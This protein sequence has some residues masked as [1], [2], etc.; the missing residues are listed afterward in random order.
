[1]QHLHK[2]GDLSSEDIETLRRLGARH[3]DDARPHL[4]LAATY[5]K[6]GWR[7]DALKQYQNAL[8]ADTR[9]KQDVHMLGDLIALAQGTKLSA[10]ASATITTSTTARKRYPR[11]TQR[12]RRPKPTAKPSQAK[13]SQGPA[14]TPARAP[15]V[16]G[17]PP[18][19]V[20]DTYRKTAKDA[21]SV[22]AVVDL[23]AGHAL[24]AFAAAAT[25]QDAGVG[26]GTALGRRARTDDAGAVAVVRA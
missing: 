20:G 18:G 24:G 2:R 9:A 12:S 19:S 7:T 22:A 23:S 5:M 21:A 8:A 14:R 3:P 10:K 4:L 6:R 1:M 16:S 11:S 15:S 25:G 13:P 26:L 17:R